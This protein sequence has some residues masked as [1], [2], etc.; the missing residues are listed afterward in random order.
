MQTGSPT[1]SVFCFLP[2]GGYHKL[3]LLLRRIRLEKPRAITHF[4]TY[5]QNRLRL[6]SLQRFGFHKNGCYNWW[7]EIEAFYFSRNEQKLFLVILMCPA[8]S[9]GAASDRSDAMFGKEPQS[10][11]DSTKYSDLHSY[12]LGSRTYQRN[13][14]GPWR[15]WVQFVIRKIQ[16]LKKVAGGEH[17]NH[18]RTFF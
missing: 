10:T 6:C 15:Y 8:G 9:P 5:L 18:S 17:L 13:K 1:C 3:S 2:L 4:Q 16:R 11:H 7:M 12:L 14:C